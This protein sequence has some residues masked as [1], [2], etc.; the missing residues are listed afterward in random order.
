ME[1]QAYPI[2]QIMTITENLKNVLSMHLHLLVFKAA[3]R[4]V[5]KIKDFFNF[6]KAKSNGLSGLSEEYERLF[7]KISGFSDFKGSGDKYHFINSIF[8]KV[9]GNECWDRL[10][11]LNARDFIIKNLKNRQLIIENADLYISHVF[12]LLGSGSIRV[13]YGLKPEGVE[14][15]VYYTNFSTTETKNYIERIN[16]RISAIF[17]SLGNEELKSLQN[18]D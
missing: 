10:I 17:N 18:H 1:L 3:R 7:L 8:S 2:S 5:I 12:D 14:N 13:Y 16:C 9:P 4:L 11:N 15:N 6:K